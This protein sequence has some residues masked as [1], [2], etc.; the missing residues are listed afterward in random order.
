M[1]SFTSNTFCNPSFPIIVSFTMSEVI[2]HSSPSPQLCAWDALTSSQAWD[3]LTSSQHQ[4][5]VPTILVSLDS[6]HHCSL[7][8][9]GPT[10]GHVSEHKSITNPGYSTLH[11]TPVG[12]ASSCRARDLGF[13]W[14][15]NLQCSWLTV[16]SMCKH[17]LL[18][19][20][21]LART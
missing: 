1:E 9:S 7:D 6:E 8:L 16:L 11:T 10:Q 13:H 17:R 5:S 2:C 15:N 18:Y 20:L 3:A 19:Q 4:T 14:L 12:P 21:L